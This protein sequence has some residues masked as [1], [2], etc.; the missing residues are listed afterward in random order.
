MSRK[1]FQIAACA[2]VALFAASAFAGCGGRR[3]S[4]SVGGGE[5]TSESTG[6]GSIDISDFPL[7]EEDYD[8]IMYTDEEYKEK[9][10]R[11]Y[12][13]GNIMYN[14]LTLPIQ[15]ENGEA[16]AKLEYTPLKVINVLDQKL[17][18]TYAEGTDYVVDAE[19]KRLVIPQGSS[20]PLISE[21]ADSGVNVPDG[22]ELSDTPD[23]YTKYTIWDLGSGPFVY[24]ESSLFYG[25]YLSVTYAYDL[26]ELPAGVF[27][28]YDPDM[29]TKVRQ[30]LEAGEDISLAVIGDSITEGSSSTGD[31]LKVDPRTPGYTRQLKEEIERVYGVSVTYTNSAKGG[32]KSEWPLSAAGTMALQHA[33]DAKPDLCVIAYGMNDGTGGVLPFEYQMNIESIMAQIKVA[34]PECEF[35]LVN[36]FPCNPLYEREPGIFDEYL[37]KLEG[38]AEKYDDGSVK[39]IDM[40]KVGN[41]F[42]ETKKYC[43]IS[44]SNVNHPNDFMHRVYAMN[45]MT[46]ICDYKNIGK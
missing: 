25:K 7:Y 18:T 19:N 12:W 23:N 33:K 22:Y 1:W 14:E 38:I 2:L 17:K 29:L 10:S 20:V 46:A 39:V 16:Y 6:G 24:T 15:Y 8:S 13:Y 5:G 42:L 35:I 45:V 34:S 40:L 44:S 32:T 31:S 41:Y 28:T 43:E 9:M 21:T 36:T 3:N 30:K 37:K 27:N 26:S 4:S 11:P